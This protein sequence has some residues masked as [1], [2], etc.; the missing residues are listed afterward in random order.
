MP[1][2]SSHFGILS[3][4]SSSPSIVEIVPATITVDANATITAA[5][6]QTGLIERSGPSA[7]RTDTLPTAAQICE[8][9]GV[10]EP[11]Y[12]VFCIRNSSGSTVT[13]AAGTGGS[14]SGTM[15]IATVAEK[16]FRIKVTNATPG[17]EAYVVQALAGGAY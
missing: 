14:T 6:L 2:V 10:S 12:F 15:T 9:V 4:R 5:Q 17:S 3:P 13:L 11:F 16:P 1:R 8:Q 7:G